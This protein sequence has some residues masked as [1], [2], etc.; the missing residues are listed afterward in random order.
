[1]KEY[2]QGYYV[3]DGK[4]TQELNANRM[5]DL[6]TKVVKHDRGCED[7]V[8]KRLTKN[9]QDFCKLMRET[10][11][12]TEAE[13][14]TP[15]EVRKSLKVKISEMHYPLWILE[16]DPEMLGYN[17]YKFCSLISKLQA[18]IFLRKFQMMINSG[19]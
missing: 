18:F 8:I 4:T 16:F 14:T 11:S 5:A 12:L 9:A 6:L 13:S 1:M 17:S 2:A 7:L 15:E 10:F 3:Y 19:P